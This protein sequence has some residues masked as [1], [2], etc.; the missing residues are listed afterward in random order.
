M[1]ILVFSSHATSSHVSNI[2]LSKAFRGLWTF[3][4]WKELSMCWRRRKKGNSGRTPGA[5]SPQEQAGDQ[6]HSTLGA[7]I[8]R[9][10]AQGLPG[11]VHEQREQ[12]PFLRNKDLKRQGQRVIRN[13]TVAARDIL[14]SFKQT[15]SKG[16]E[17]QFFWS[18]FDSPRSEHLLAS[19]KSTQSLTARLQPQGNTKLEVVIQAKGKKRSNFTDLKPE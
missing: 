4:W 15:L 18:C 8:L 11:K 6:G 19:Q 5:T 12:R 13:T 2:D 7:V 9:R 1:T 17:E 10:K 14:T 3:T 16:R